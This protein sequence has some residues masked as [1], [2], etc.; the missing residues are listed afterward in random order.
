M[1]DPELT[2]DEPVASAR[3]LRQFAG[4]W[5]AI[6]G[7]L[8][9]WSLYRGDAGRAIGLAVVALVIGPLGLARPMAIRPFFS[10]LLTLTRPIGAIVNWVILAIMFYGLFTPLALVFKL[11]GRDALALKRPT[12]T[13]TY[14]KRRR[15][16]TDA[17]R[18]FRQ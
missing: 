14:W 5:L 9:A 6:V 16:V 8:S 7:G 18:Y 1:V 17:R 3:V 12:G 13:T 15:A 11:A 2:E 4:L 10:L